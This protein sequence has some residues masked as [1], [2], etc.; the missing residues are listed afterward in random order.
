MAKK[1]GF[2]CTTIFHYH[3]FKRIA[4]Y[5]KDNAIFII[6]TPKIV[7]KRYQRLESYFQQHNV[8]Y[9]NVSQL[10]KGEIDIDVV[11]SP[12]YM[13]VF[14]LMD[15]EIFRVRMLYGYAKDAWNYADWNKGFDLILVYGPYAERKLRKMAPTIVVGHP[16][17]Q[18]LPDGKLNNEV[19]S[20]NNEPLSSWLSS[21]K[22][23]LYCP[24]WGEISSIYQIEAIINEVTSEYDLIIKLH[25]GNVLSDRIDIGSYVNN[26]SVFI[27]DERT[28]LFD[29]F[30]V[31]DIVLSDYSGAIF[32]AILAKKKVV[33]ID[34]LN[35]SIVN[36]GVANLRKMTNIARYEE[37]SKN[38]QEESLDIMIRNYIPHISNVNEL[39]RMISQELN[40]KYSFP[41]Q[42]YY[43]LFSYI[44]GNGAKRAAEEIEK[45]SQNHAYRKRD[46]FFELINKDLLKKFTQSNHTFK[47]VIW[48]A[49]ELGQMFYH[50]LI[51][52]KLKVSH[53]IDVDPNKQGKYVEGVKVTS[54]DT[55]NEIHNHKIIIA[56]YAARDEIKNILL[57]KNLVEERDFV[58]PFN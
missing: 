50:W 49:G 9:C 52:N 43:D 28:D 32:D 54:L 41:E 55:L 1:I 39:K 34:S 53:F 2:L 24:T 29:I 4:S 45:W 19:Y 16:R 26:K 47:F 6:S 57:S 7:N 12:Y 27:C 25:H 11:V 51:K 56:S 22:V 38:N 46:S 36:T 21:K 3:H 30:P 5:F 20:I 40:K 13:P 58:L 37:N 8:N 18:N 33:L 42:I 14:S 23:V 48:G 44:D 31:V 15:E 10:I 17:F 35:E